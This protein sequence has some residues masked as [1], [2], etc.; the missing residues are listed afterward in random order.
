MGCCSQYSDPVH[1]GTD[2]FR[3][4]MEFIDRRDDE[5]YKA[6]HAPW[7]GG[8]YIKDREPFCL[9]I[10]CCDDHQED[11]LYMIRDSD[12][13]WYLRRVESVGKGKVVAMLKS[14]QRL[15]RSISLDH[16]NH[17]NLM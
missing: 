17:I 6:C 13:E 8:F 11:A 14:A 16:T 9:E 3:D 2:G 7:T 10:Y 15:R 1:N 12:F 4:E 5:D